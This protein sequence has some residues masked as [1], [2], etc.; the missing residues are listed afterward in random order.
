MCQPEA[1]APRRG[2]AWN[3]PLRN[4]S[5][6][7]PYGFAEL[8]Q[9]R[10]HLNWKRRWRGGEDGRRSRRPPRD[11]KAAAVLGVS[12]RSGNARHR[13]PGRVRAVG[14][15]VG[16]HRGRSARRSSGPAVHSAPKAARAP[17][18][19]GGGVLPQRRLV[20]YRATRPYRQW[21]RGG[22][23]GYDQVATC[24][25]EG[26]RGLV[27]AEEERTRVHH[28]ASCEK[29]VRPS[30]CLRRRGERGSADGKQRS[31]GG[32]DRHRRRGAGDAGVHGACLPVM[33]ASTREEMRRI[34]FT[35]RSSSRLFL[36]HS[37]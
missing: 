36:I 29:R 18:S 28:R 5:S 24:S 14:V 32:S 22:V 25:V 23:P 17:R 2:T 30:F 10:A 26:L 6:G 35:S 11:R 13:P 8:F 15:A 1:A 21:R 34:S 12:S 20:C 33:R 31:Q 3:G 4:V 37:R 7:V 16:R 19:R 27:P 9:A